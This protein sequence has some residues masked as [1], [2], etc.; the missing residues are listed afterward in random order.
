MWWRKKESNVNFSIY[1]I[2]M[3]TAIERPF[4][5]G[6]HYFARIRCKNKFNAGR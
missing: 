3:T 6:I 5:G 2:M 4:N 1:N